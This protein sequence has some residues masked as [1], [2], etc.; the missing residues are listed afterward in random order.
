MS[1]ALV[2]AIL[3]TSVAGVAV[4]LPSLRLK[5]DA[6][7]LATLGFGIVIVTIIHNWSDVTGGPKGFPE[8]VEA[9]R[10]VTIIPRIFGWELDTPL[11]YLMFCSAVGAV[12]AWLL[13]KVKISPFGRTLR[14]IRED[15]ISAE[16]LGKRVTLFKA[17]A[18]VT[19]AAFAGVAGALF[20]GYMRYLHT[21]SF[22]PMESI[23]IVSILIIGG[24]GTFRGPLVGAVLLVALPEA[25]R[26]LRLPDVTAANIR[27]MIYGVSLIILMRH[28]PQG[29]LGEYRLG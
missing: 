26:F 14:A 27:Q 9:V 22:S 13:W 2:A 3:V 1:G 21:H 11:R 5:G 25:L 23:S 18:F 4:A 28:R 17:T 29:L 24:S 12:C 16:S 19:A 10:N 20:A 8:G 7:I 15:E 6:F